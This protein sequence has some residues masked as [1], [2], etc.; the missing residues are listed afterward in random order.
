MR[1]GFLLVMRIGVAL[2][3][4]CIHLQL[5]FG[6]G[7]FFERAVF[8]Y[9]THPDLPL[10]NYVRG[11][12]G[13]IRPEFKGPA[14]YV[15]YRHL[16]G[17]G[18]NTTEQEA[19][20]HVWKTFL[21]MEWDASSPPYS[22]QQ[23]QAVRSQ[24][25]DLPPVPEPQ[26][27]RTIAA[28]YSSYW[29]CLDDAFLTAARTLQERIAQFGAQSVAVKAW[30]QAQDQ[31]FANCSESETIPPTAEATLPPLIQADRAYQ[32]AA[33]YFYTEQFDEAAR[34]FAD[35]A[36]DTT[37]PWRALAAYLLARTYLRKATFTTTEGGVNT[38]LLTQAEA[39]LQQVLAD[40]TLST[41]HPAA[42][43]LLDHIRSRLSPEEQWRRI[44]ARLLQPRLAATLAQD[45]RDS[46]LL[47]QWFSHRPEGE[48]RVMM[49][50]DELADWLLTFRGS[51]ESAFTY[52]WERWQATHS[53]AWL[54]AALT[55]CQ[56]SH[57]Q[58]PVLLESAAKVPPAAPA[59][60]TVTFHRIRLLI[61]ANQLDEARA[62]LE[63]LLTVDKMPMPP[64][65]RNLFIAQRRS[66]ARNLD[67]FLSD[68]PHIPVGV[69][70]DLPE[71]NEMPQNPQYSSGAE[72]LAD[73]KLLFDDEAAGVLN[74]L[75]L[76]M[77]AQ[78]AANSVRFP[79][80]LRREVALAVWTKAALLNEDKTAKQLS[81]TLI[82]LYPDLQE[83]LSA[84]QKART[85]KERTFVLTFLLLRRPGMWPYVRSGLGRLTPIDEIDGYRD[86]WWGCQATI[87]SPS[88]LVAFSLATPFLSVA[89]Q[90]VAAEETGKI[91]TVEQLFRQVLTWA[92]R[93]PQ[94][95][96]V[97][98]ALSRVVKSAR[99]GCTSSALSKEAFQFL[100]KRYPGNEWTKKT[101]YWY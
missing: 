35:I 59:F 83:D 10:E 67:E 39:Q 16:Q 12:L 4:W 99:Y 81:S 34:R 82:Q 71:Y 15:A 1:A 101:K 14:L 17:L 22:L 68:A 29:N 47:P 45:L 9:V 27:Y 62:L 64:S 51:D 26:V 40:N 43:R 94:D 73:N 8:S 49:R 32:I 97:P 70:V 66:L 25:P 65:S 85:Q 98:E 61:E 13:I 100:H 75:P 53:Q 96:R 77:L 54:V 7:P 84:Y 5:A 28:T 78:V 56:V 57:T 91:P 69:I 23:W 63:T 86:N 21:G 6:S 31:V 18:F 76:S 30:T 38:A 92:R 48:R 41:I 88:S 90:A 72:L 89:Q 42:Q 44:N 11:D 3:A 55:N 79:T 74:S 93:H 46:L 2:V 95:D 37:S 19:V 58:L 24:I 80:H 60:L 36:T 52:A 50:K 20:L 33:A 87:A